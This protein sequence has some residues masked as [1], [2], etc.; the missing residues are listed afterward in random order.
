[1]WKLFSFMGVGRPSRL[2]GGGCSIWGVCRARLG[3]LSFPNSAISGPG[4]T[5]GPTCGW[6]SKEGATRDTSR[7]DSGHAMAML[8]V[9]SERA[10][11]RRAH[12]DLNQGPA[13]LQS[14]ALTTELCT[15]MLTCVA[16]VKC[17][18]H[19]QLNCHR[20]AG[21][22]IPLAPLGDT[23]SIRYSLAG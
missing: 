6:G 3:R 7:R 12:P 8:A 11:H 16:A 22:M 18:R 1:M 14:A 15:Q 13:D 17:N 10:S 5:S 19:Q 20:E 21:A 2:S 23:T 4:L 9:G